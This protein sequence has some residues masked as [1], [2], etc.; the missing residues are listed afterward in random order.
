MKLDDWLAQ[1]AISCPERTALVTEA[2]SVTYAELE[3]EATW[4]ARRLAASGVR[5]GGI[6]ALTMH[7]RREEV[8][9]LHALMKL[10]AVALPLSPQLT[11]AERAS[12]LAAFQPLLER[13]VFV[14][15]PQHY[16]K[17]KRHFG[18]RVRL[19][20]ADARLR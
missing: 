7:P 15:G 8:V 14:Y 20:L 6:A 2:S 13:K 19:A 5:R 4:V 1:R 3:A 10:G 11:E 12:V 18:Q 16:R 9:L 17:L